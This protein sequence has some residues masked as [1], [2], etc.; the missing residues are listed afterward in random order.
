[1]WRVVLWKMGFVTLRCV[2]WLCRLGLLRCGS[3]KSRLKAHN[4][5]QYHR[6]WDMLQVMTGPLFLVLV[7]A[8]SKQQSAR[9][10]TELETMLTIS[11]KTSS[12]ALE[13]DGN[14]DCEH[15]IPI[16]EFG[17]TWHK[18]SE[19]RPQDIANVW[20]W[21]TQNLSNFVLAL[22]WEKVHFCS[23]YLDSK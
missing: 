12:V 20:N 7:A 10:V 4:Y 19:T 3:R 23:D 18:V 17:L 13:L 9:S 14:W 5:Q 1:M 15:C 16:T 21:I 6:S 2:H 8:F 11:T 22:K